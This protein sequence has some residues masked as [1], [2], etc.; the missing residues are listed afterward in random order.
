MARMVVGLTLQKQRVLIRAPGRVEEAACADAPEDCCPDG[1]PGG[2]GGDCCP[3]G[4]AASL[5]FVVES[6]VAILGDM[7]RFE[8]ALVPDPGGAMW[9][10]EEPVEGSSGLGATAT[11]LNSLLLYCEGGE[12]WIE[13]AITDI[14]SVT[15]RALQRLS[16]T[17]DSLGAIFDLP[18]ALPGGT[19]VVIEHPCPGETRV[20]CVDLFPGVCA[21][22]LRISSRW[23]VR[24][25]ADE[26]QDWVALSDSGECVFRSVLVPDAWVLTYSEGYYLLTAAD[27][28]TWSV[29]DNAWSCC[30][31]NFMAAQDPGEVDY[32]LVP[33]YDCCG[34]LPT[35]NCTDGACVEA[36]D[37][38]YASLAECEAACGP[39]INCMGTE[40]TAPGTLTLAFYGGTGVYTP[41]NGLSYTLS[42]NGTNWAVATPGP[43]FTELSMA[44]SDPG[45][46]GT[47][48]TFAITFSGCF[49]FV[50]GNQP[51]TCAP[52]S[53]SNSGVAGPGTCGGPGL[54]YVG[55]T[56]S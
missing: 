10:L 32:I 37:G 52:F 46:G 22:C 42:W 38:T 7:A 28:R 49:D 17:G 2:A 18:G 25:G 33:V 12:W 5:P 14:A 8:G 53:I 4:A 1:D 23:E 29:D 16:D 21:P 40:T 44:L 45:S 13:I 20:D 47:L 9:Y 54:D 15:R 35:Y 3:E 24:N 39:T 6:P 51:M 48:P 50:S 26:L 43:F 30:G 34:P 11:T 31:T 36:A 19:A 41:L 56:I 27:G 55:F